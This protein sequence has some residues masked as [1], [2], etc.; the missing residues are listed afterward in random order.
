MLATAGAKVVLGA[1]R[2]D[3]ITALAVELDGAA[4]ATDVTKRADVEALVALAVERFGKLD[5][6]VG[7]AGIARIGPL[8]ELA[9][10]DWLA[11]VDVNLNGFLYGIAAALPVFRRQG[12]GHFVTTI[13][14][15]GLKIVPDQSI[16]AGTKNAVRT[17]HEGL[18]QEAG[19]HLRVTG[20]SP[21]YVRTELA[22]ASIQH[23]EMRK[24]VE[25][26]MA[27][28]AISPEAIARAIAFAIDQPDDV[29]VG[30]I[31]VR[32]TAQS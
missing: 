21:G 18:R 17:I 24:Q 32:P 12:F 23:E 25:E 28:I 2:I 26:R 15:S 31:I 13:S 22:T 6:F 4:R 8:D 11:M 14:T 5:V 9:V 30:D 16:Y 20:I 3:R 10:D 27:K 29:D 1:R 19:P 7:N